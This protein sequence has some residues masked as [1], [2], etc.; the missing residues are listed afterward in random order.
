MVPHLA[1]MDFSGSLVGVVFEVVK[2]WRRCC[3]RRAIAVRSEQR[4]R[5]GSR[6]AAGHCCDTTP[7]HI[8]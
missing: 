7:E 1:V 5:S 3:P 6:S 2:V 8:Y 4:E